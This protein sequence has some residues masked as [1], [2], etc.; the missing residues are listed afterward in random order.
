MYKKFNLCK[1][2]KINI[3]RKLNYKINN[4]F[5]KKIIMAFCVISLQQEIKALYIILPDKPLPKKHTKQQYFDSR[6]SLIEYLGTYVLTILDDVLLNW[7]VSRR[8]YFFKN[9]LGQLKQVDVIIELLKYSREACMCGKI[10]MFYDSIIK[11]NKKF[12]D[13][14]NIISEHKLSNNFV[15]KKFYEIVNNELKRSINCFRVGTDW[16]AEELLNILCFYEKFKTKVRKL[17]FWQKLEYKKKIHFTT[18]DVGIYDL[19]IDKDNTI[20]YKQLIDELKNKLLHIST[21]YDALYICDYIRNFDSD[22]WFIACLLNK[23][24][25]AN[26][27]GTMYHLKNLQKIII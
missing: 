20:D 5:L 22:V 15:S 8:L 18:G 6:L 7:D 1:I 25:T 16:L 21:Y 10:L 13:H 3:T 11:Y 23:Y 26:I 19:K 9:S 17:K 12:I 14:M 27:N 24:I 4:M 2:R